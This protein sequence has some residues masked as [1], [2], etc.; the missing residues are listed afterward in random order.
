MLQ[1][2]GVVAIAAV[3]SVEL[4]EGTISPAFILVVAGVLLVLGWAFAWAASGGKLGRSVP[5][6][7]W[8]VTMLLV[9]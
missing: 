1:Q 4:Y 6:A 3:A 7:A 9:G 2:L 5:R 8:Q